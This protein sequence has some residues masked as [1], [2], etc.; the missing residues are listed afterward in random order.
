LTGV[1]LVIEGF[2]KDRTG[3][4][5]SRLTYI[6]TTI[7][8]RFIYGRNPSWGSPALPGIICIIWRIYK[9]WG[10]LRFSLL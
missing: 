9:S 6:L 1:E 10:L 8:R 7:K 3:Y 5:T 4:P 2:D